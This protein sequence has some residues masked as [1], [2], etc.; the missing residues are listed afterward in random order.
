V[1]HARADLVFEPRA[2]FL[3]VVHRSRGAM[4]SLARAGRP[5]TARH[6]WWPTRRFP[7]GAPAGI[8]VPAAAAAAAASAVAV[9]DS[10]LGQRGA[11][12]IYPLRIVHL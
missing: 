5:R 2:L 8:A 1:A 10:T 3:I 9:P 11:A 6:H 12:E 4:H 7:G